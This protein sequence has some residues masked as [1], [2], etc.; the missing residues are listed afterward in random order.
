M[1]AAKNTFIDSMLEVLGDNIFSGLE[2]YPEITGTMLT[3]ANPD[4]IFL[5]TEPYSFS[6]N[7]YLNSN[8]FHHAPALFWLMAKCSP[9]RQPVKI[10]ARVF[11]P[12]GLHLLD[13]SQIRSNKF[14]KAIPAFVFV[15]TGQYIRPSNKKHENY[16]TMV[17]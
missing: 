16:S 17:G 12:I 1:V 4:Y 5:S 15:I 10:G 9:V 14:K 11:Y 2:R 7:I 6:K 8:P 13:L 3:E